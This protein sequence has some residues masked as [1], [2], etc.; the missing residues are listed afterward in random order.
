MRMDSLELSLC[1]QHIIISYPLGVCHQTDSQLHNLQK[2]YIPV[3]LNKLGFVHTYA[4]SIV[5]GP[6]F[7]GGIGTIDLT[8]EQGIMIIYEVMRT[9]RTPGQGQELLRIFLRKFQHTSDLSLLLLEY[10][11]KR[12][13]HLKGY[14]YLYLQNFLAEH[15]CQL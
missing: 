5:F 6:R 8:I 15:G 2:K 11:V 12:A 9:I 10:P 14:Y 7:H 4:Q 1:L 3:A 13:P